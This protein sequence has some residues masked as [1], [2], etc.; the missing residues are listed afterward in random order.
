LFAQWRRRFTFA[1]WRVLV[2]G[3]D[4][5]ES[6]LHS[7]PLD[8]AFTGGQ[9]QALPSIHDECLRIP[10][11]TGG[12]NSI[13]GAGTWYEGVMTSGYP[14]GAAENAVQAD[15]VAAGYR[16]TGHSGPCDDRAAPGTRPGGGST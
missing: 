6:E 9:P 11:G 4:L 13:Q 14:S 12:D 2:G 3:P 8:D 16:W 15:I 10:L 5:P 7:R 1:S